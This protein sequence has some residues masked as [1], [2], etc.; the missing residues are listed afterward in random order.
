MTIRRSALAVLCAL[1][2]SCDPLARSELSLTFEEGGD[3]VRIRVDSGE[4]HLRVNHAGDRDRIVDETLAGRDEWSA[5][6]ASAGVE[7][8]SLSFERTKG[9]VTRITHEAA[10]G[11]SQ[12]QSF[13]SNTGVT[14]QL[15]RDG[16][17]I[18]LTLYPG[19]SM[20]ATRQQREIVARRLDEFAKLVVAWLD[21]MRP[22]YSY[23]EA[24]PSRAEQLFFAFYADEKDRPELSDHEALLTSAARRAA[25]ALMKAEEES[26]RELPRFADLVYNPFPALVK[27]NIP[28]APLEVEGF[29]SSE[30]GPLVA[31]TATPF[32]AFV[33]LQGR[34][35]EPDPLALALTGK[36][37]DARAAARRLAAA[38]RKASPAVTASEVVAAIVE[39]IRPASRYRVRW[40]ASEAPRR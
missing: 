14:A 25:E 16:G 10:I 3:K 17:T 31:T 37:F 12:L 2:L 26:E 21:A 15:V 33:A 8:E 28:A 1:L 4:E 13:F 35:M 34:W 39:G 7:R 32:E 18:E 29:T 20:R 30:E 5:R 23:L 38:T 22:L 24:N 27:V 40:P 19:A 9:R 6:F 36:D 11:A